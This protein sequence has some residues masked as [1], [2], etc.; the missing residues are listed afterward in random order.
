MR[1]F[2]QQIF[3]ERYGR[4]AVEEWHLQ[5]HDDF[6]KL[7]TPDPKTHKS[8][9]PDILSMQGEGR[10]LICCPEDQICR[11]TCPID[12]RLCL[13]C[14]IPICADC[15]FCLTK[16]QLSPMSLVNDN[17]VGYLDPWIYEHD[18]T[19]MEKT[20]A[21]PFWIGMTL[22]SIDRKQHIVGRSTTF[23]MPSTRGED[24]F[25]SKDSCSAPPWTGRVCWNSW[26]EPRRRKRS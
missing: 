10:G 11:R 24:A 9:Y 16:N 15:R 23:S 12:K 17:F 22:F 18:I 1:N 19:W 13:E 8:R 26:R 4:P 14:R 21:T 7:A 2:S 6:M 3:E 25:Y 5:W 20:V